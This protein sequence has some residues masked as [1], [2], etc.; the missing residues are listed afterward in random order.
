MQVYK[1]YT[2]PVSLLQIVVF[3]GL[4]D[5]NLIDNSIERIRKKYPEPCPLK[6]LLQAE[7]EKKKAQNE[8]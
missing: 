7:S 6:C 1:P 5:V 8:I 2:K 3:R 4:P